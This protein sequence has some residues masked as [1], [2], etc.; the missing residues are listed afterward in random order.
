MILILLSLLLLSLLFELLLLLLLL[1][2]FII[3]IIKVLQNY[4]MKGRLGALEAQ[5]AQINASVG[6]L[7]R[8]Q[9][10]CLSLSLYIYI[11]IE[12]EIHGYMYVYIYIYIYI[13]VYIYIYIKRER[14]RDQFIVIAIIITIIVII[15]NSIIILCWRGYRWS[16]ARR[17]SCGRTPTFA[18]R[19]LMI[20]YNRYRIIGHDLL[21]W[22]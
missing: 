9:V 17:P 1:F 22:L 11:Y 13:Y 10:D 14:E 19:S 6:S 7:A 18:C 2:E 15:I 16:S 8:L 12:R 3:I 21:L 5:L 4:W 20:Y